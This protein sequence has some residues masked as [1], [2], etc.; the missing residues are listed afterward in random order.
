MLALQ[1]R[2]SMSSR[3]IVRLMKHSSR[4]AERLDEEDRAET[5]VGVFRNTAAL[6]ILGG[7]VLMLLDEV[8]IPVVPLMGGAAVFGLAVAFAAQNLI[9]DYFSGFLV[10]LE[11]QSAV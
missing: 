6:L 8:G 1:R 4:K 2:A 3:R 7:G 10:L 9:Q 11:E 5:L